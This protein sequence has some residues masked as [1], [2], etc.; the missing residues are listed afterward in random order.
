MGLFGVHGVT[1]ADNRFDEDEPGTNSSGGEDNIGGGAGSSGL[2]I[3]GN[4]WA[5]SA[6]GNA[7]NLTVADHA[8]VRG[9]ESWLPGV[10]FE[11]VTDST[12][13]G[14]DLHGRFAGINL[15][16]NSDY[17]GSVSTSGVRQPRNDVV[18]GNRIS[19]APF[20]GI[21][22]FYFP[23]RGYRLGHLDPTY[24]EPPTTVEGG[25]NVIQG[26]TLAR[27]EG[28]G[29]LAAAC[30]GAV[31]T[32]ADSIA[33]NTITDVNWH[34]TSAYTSGCGQFAAPTGI[35]V[36]AAAGTTIGTNV[37]TDTRT[38]TPMTSAAVP[39]SGPQT[40]SAV[41][42]GTSNVHVDR[43]PVP[44]IGLMAP[45]TVK[46]LT[47]PAVKWNVPMPTKLSV[48]ADE[49]GGTVLTL[50]GY[51][52]ET[53]D[54]RTAGGVTIG[55]QPAGDLSVASAPDRAGSSTMT[56]V[57]PAG[58]GTAAL[59]LRAA[60]GRT[61][62]RT[63]S[64]SYGP[65]VDAVLPPSTILQPGGG[66]SLVV[67]TSTPV[68]ASAP[69]FAA[70][71]LTA[72][73]NGVRAGSSWVGP[74]SVRL[75]SPPVDPGPASVVLWRDGV[76]GAADTTATVP[77]LV[78]RLSA[79]SGSEAGGTKVTVTGFGFTGATNWRFGTVPAT[80]AI[81]SAKQ[82]SCVVPAGAP[83]SVAVQFDPAPGIQ[84]MDT[85]AATWTYRAT[86]RV[87]PN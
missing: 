87:A 74:T 78:S 26:N 33:G 7:I 4:R 75:V 80:C 29:I 27:A 40:A 9:N 36:S 66:T 73:V 10:I 12:I 3:R 11:G 25:G 48:R 62:G 52:L 18:S 24:H 8:T 84:R 68:G 50:T 76:A 86:V 34:G 38:G 53:V 1:V 47:G 16:P 22:L 67:T 56:L 6:V 45:Q 60:D 49:R 69:A 39:T 35:A 61:S 30:G 41:T 21:V 82:A 14:N 15:K 81:V 28:A 5:P 85:P 65:A 54:R 83:G 13:T 77:A 17:E 44:V 20:A 2:V 58:S 51:G 55:G 32:K 71:R 70:L 79:V 37:V 63:L 23:T 64:M 19:D 46:N 57:A 31:Y 59:A 72:T 43:A 42:I